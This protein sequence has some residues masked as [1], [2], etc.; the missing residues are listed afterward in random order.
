MQL[1]ILL[2]CSICAFNVLSV[3]AQSDSM[4]WVPKHMIAGQQY[5]GMILT[6]NAAD[7]TN[8]VLSS[9]DYNILQIQNHTTIPK[10][11]NHG[12]FSMTP[13]LSGNAEIFA[14]IDDQLFTE[15]TMIFSPKSQPQKLSL[16]TPANKTKTDSMLAYV[17]LLDDNNLPISANQNIKVYF[18]ASSGIDAPSYTIIRNGTS[19]KSF[20]MDISGT[21]KITVSAEKLEPHTV[22]IT[23]SQNNYDVMIAVAPYIAMSDSHA[24]YY[25]WLEKNGK[26]FHPS[27]VVD[28]FVHSNDHSVARFDANPSL[29]K[30]L[31]SLVHLVD[32]VGKGILYTGNRGY[33]VITASVAEFGTGKDTLFVGPARF[34]SM[35]DDY[36][37]VRV[38][39]QNLLY[40]NEN[41]DV[42]PNYLDVLIYPSITNQHAWMVVA[43]YSVNKTQNLELVVDNFGIAKN[44]KI[45]N[46]IKT[47]ARING[48]TI[49]VSS[50][51]GL[52]HH[53]TYTLD[54][55]LTKTNAAEFEI[56][57]F[58]HG[59][60][61]VTVSGSGLESASTTVHVTP[62]YSKEFSI[63]LTE[64]PALPG[65]LQDVAIISIL[66]ETGALV[67]AQ[68]VFGND[69]QFLIHTESGIADSL[70]AKH[71]GSAILAAVLNGPEDITI[72]L[73]GLGAI[74]MTLTPAR[75]ASSL[76]ILGP[77]LVHVTEEFPLVI[78]STDVYG[79]LIEKINDIELSSSLD[80]QKT[81]DNFSLYDAGSGKVSVISPH[82]AAQYELTGFENVMNP[83]L[84]MKKTDFRVGEN[85]T[86]T[87]LNSV[88]ADYFIQTDFPYIWQDKDTFVIMLDAENQQSILSVTATRDGYMPVTISESFSV[89]KI[90]SLYVQAF[91][92]NGARLYLPF[93]VDIGPDSISA[94]T[95]YHKEIKPNQIQINFPN[96]IVIS[97]QGYVF[98]NMTI[99][100]VAFSYSNFT[101]Y[102]FRDLDI[103]LIY[104]KEI[105][106]SVIDGE[107]SGVYM[108]GDVVNI[109]A[110]DKPRILF[111]VRDVFDHWEGLDSE[112]SQTSIT[113]YSDIELVAIYRIDYTY[114]M[115]LILI[116]LISVGFFS[117]FRKT[118]SVRWNMQN[119]IEKLFSVLK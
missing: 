64:I 24:F 59:N 31:G 95:P 108:Y 53:S 111:L 77:T 103:V 22:T 116:P 70:F 14:V 51:H 48:N 21:G 35:H 42:L 27:Y 8:V 62:I 76:E 102:L 98:E 55:H 79:N 82:G 30:S 101:E 91:D 60:Y 52:K 45:E 56:T 1:V 11:L 86:V 97:E 85:I 104:D 46:T 73:D 54:E 44:S 96:K 61:T 81:G 113:A 18:T 71:S 65:I 19:S 66:D 47:P 110:P 13:I 100:D 17:V 58:N 99:N 10:H 115:V 118:S 117:V 89:Q 15:S 26:P 5:Y 40:H 39:Q 90:F 93:D 38:N 68:D 75:I 72:S 29:E 9:D 41:N 16:I 88:N 28:A 33:S 87:I 34:T 107:G 49:H 80:L 37:N 57:G 109:S 2:I 63:I 106:V 92:T 112:F 114:L 94:Q 67:D 20:E 12:I 36:L 69:M 7:S 83:V 4:I 23:K 3:A 43:A 119:W 6:Q 32:G 105:H 78:H 74:S 84:D 50:S 25:I